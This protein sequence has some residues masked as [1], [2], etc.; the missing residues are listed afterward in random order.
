MPTGVE[1]GVG[2][3]V[4]VSLAILAGLFSAELSSMEAPARNCRRSSAM[5]RTAEYRSVA[6]FERAFRQMRS[7]SRGIAS[8]I[9]RGG[10]TSMS[11]I[12]SSKS[13]RRWA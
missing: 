12:C 7:S 8:L 10:R 6:R 3:G 1:A 4:A 13:F 5:S 9:C 11:E 2:T